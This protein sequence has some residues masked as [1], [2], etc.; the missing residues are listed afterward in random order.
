MEEFDIYEFVVSYIY[1]GN[2]TQTSIIAADELTAIKL[3]SDIYCE[4]NKICVLSTALHEKVDDCKRA[5]CV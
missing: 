4:S 5:A 3:I 1:V 2:L